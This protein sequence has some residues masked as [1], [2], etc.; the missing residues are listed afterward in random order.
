VQA[1]S[2][3]GRDGAARGL[4]RRPACMGITLGTKGSNH[5][6]LDIFWVDH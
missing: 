6:A 3:A 2:G 1:C 5:L 4:R